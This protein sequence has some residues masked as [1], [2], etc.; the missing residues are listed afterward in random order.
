MAR[1]IRIPPA[2]ALGRLPELQLI[3]VVAPVLNEEATLRTF[4]DR[5]RSVLADL[6]FEL[7]LVDDGSTDGTPELLRSLAGADPRVCVVRLSRNFGY[8]AAVTAG[9]DH[10]R[11]DVIVTIDADL[12]DPPELIPQLVAAWRE[13]A[14]VVYAYREERSGETW[15]KLRTARWFARVFAR[16]ARVDLPHNIGDYRL[17]DR[18]AVDALLSMREH[19]RF[20]R[21]M[22][23]WVGFTQTTVPYRREQRHSGQT[24]YRWR[25]LIGISL[26]ALSSFSHAPL[27]LATFLGFIVSFVAFLGIPYVV[28]SSL[29]GIYVEGISTVLFAVLMLGGIQLI[30][31]GIIGEYISRIYDEVKGRPLYVVRERHNVVAPDHQPDAADH[32]VAIG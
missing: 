28:V 23:I 25:T 7:V 29:L 30:T 18:R 13:G 31:L 16:L 2:Y 20:L 17:M 14:D 12:Q 19:S 10:A 1:R 15:L 5:V 32:R 22:A 6:P 8:Q 26:D 3:S 21:G 11:G 27:Q 24:R 4:Y 9:L